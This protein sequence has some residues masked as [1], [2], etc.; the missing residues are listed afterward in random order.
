MRQ[1]WMIGALALLVGCGAEESASPAGQD[2]RA[3]EEAGL[4]E[5]S[6]AGA[7]G[8]EAVRGYALEGKV[9]DPWSSPIA[10][11]TIRVWPAGSSEDQPELASTESDANGHYAFELDG[12]GPFVLVARHAQ[13]GYDSIESHLLQRAAANEAPVLWLAGE[14]RFAGRLTNVADEPIAQAKVI[15]FSRELLQQEMYRGNE[16]LKLEDLPLWVPRMDSPHFQPGRGFAYKEDVTDAQGRFALK[17]LVP[18]EYLFFSPAIGGRPWLDLERTWHAT[19]SMDIELRS[20]L[21][22]LEVA[23][24]QD[25]L[26]GSNAETPEKRR[27]LG[28]IEVFATVPSAFGS[29]PLLGRGIQ[30]YA[31]ERNVFMLEPGDYIVRALTIPPAGQFGGT[32]SV[33]SRVRLEAGE[34]FKRLNLEFPSLERPTG[35]LRVSAEVPKDWEAPRSFRLLSPLTGRE[36]EC[37]EYTPYPVLKFDEWLDVPEGE[38]WIALMPFSDLVGRPEVVQIAPCYRRI[39]I[40]AGTE[41][42]STLRATFGGKFR[43]KLDADRFV[44]GRDYLKPGDFGHGDET[45]LLQLFSLTIGATVTVVREDGGPAVKLRLRD[46]LARLREE[47]KTMLPGERFENIVPLEPGEYV[48]WADAPGYEPGSVPFTV[49][50]RGRSDVDLRLK[51]ISKF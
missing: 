31:Q 11:A 30:P 51:S 10:G 50:G 9:L 19:G 47:R 4:D 12:P 43:L 37:S 27:R 1:M 32:L 39:E 49:T 22:T 44:L 15:A 40:K 23:V 36:L 35:R 41:M 20:N 16:A 24:G 18:G 21:C 33:E 38:Y 7:A 48:L 8:D 13:S 5:P 29:R 6:A 42:E 34:T 46:P 25:G 3:A 45:D 2:A 28:A 26:P 17:G 14:G